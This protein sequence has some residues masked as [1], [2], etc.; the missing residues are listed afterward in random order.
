MRAAAFLMSLL[1]AFFLVRCAGEQ[2]TPAQEKVLS[3]FECRVHALQPYVGSVYD[4]AEL[5]RDA[6]AGK[7]ELMRVLQALGYAPEDIAQIA[8]AFGSCE[9][10]LAPPP[11]PGGKVL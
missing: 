9:P 5:V 4:T 3:L 6:A 10:V 8:S 7:T 1:T 11:H 2:L